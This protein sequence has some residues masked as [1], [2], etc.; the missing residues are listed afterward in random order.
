MC[1]MCFK[2]TEALDTHTKVVLNIAGHLL[3]RHA[4]LMLAYTTGT[5]APSEVYADLR[6]LELRIDMLA[7]ELKIATDSNK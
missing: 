5:R 7:K 1:D 4:N 6:E 3:K 2:S